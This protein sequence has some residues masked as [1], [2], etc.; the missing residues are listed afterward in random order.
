MSR[1]VDWE[2]PAGRRHFTRWRPRIEFRPSAQE[3]GDRLFNRDYRYW[4]Q[5]S[6]RR[7]AGPV[8]AR[9]N[10]PYQA[11]EQIRAR[12]IPW[13]NRS[14]FHRRYGDDAD[15]DQ[16]LVDRRYREDD[17]ADPRVFEDLVFQRRHDFRSPY[18][19]Y[20]K[21]TLTPY[22]LENIQYEEDIAAEDEPWRQTKER[23]WK[24]HA[25]RERESTPDV[26]D[27]PLVTVGKKIKFEDAE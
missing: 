4:R 6:G 12:N 7:R 8:F 25:K 24:H 9:S 17:L 13:M 15:Y 23:A 2:S 19:D 1:P 18:N 22:E 11:N 5:Y 27:L 26:E 14:Q 20:D 10:V 21:L 16:W 3:R